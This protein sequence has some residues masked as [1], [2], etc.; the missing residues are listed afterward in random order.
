LEVTSKEVVPLAAFTLC[1]AGL[2]NKMG[3]APACSTVTTT[4]VAPA[5]ET[6]MLAI[7]GNVERF[8]AKVA[9]RVPLPVCPAL[10]VH[11]SASLSVAHPRLEVTSKEVVPLA[12]FTLCEA[13]LTNKM[14][15]APACSTVT[16]TDA[17]PVAETVM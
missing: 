14:G 6:V 13:G 2:T 1:E 11:Q 4:G 9:V 16:M 17:T 5:A 10:T 3:S 7:R 8:A 12:A 15:S